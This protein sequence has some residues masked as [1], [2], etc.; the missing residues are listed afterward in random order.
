MRNNSILLHSSP[1]SNIKSS[2]LTWLNVTCYFYHQEPSSHKQNIHL[3]LWLEGTI[4]KHW[5]LKAL[6]FK[7]SP[8][9]LPSPKLY[10][11]LNFAVFKTASAIDSQWC[12]YVTRKKC[13]LLGVENR[14]NWSV[15]RC[16]AKKKS[17]MKF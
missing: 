4:I 14:N 10:A 3:D 6:G 12:Y 17:L 11:S 13:V 15:N 9:F 8:E 5:D 1:T 7:K 16:A 2:M